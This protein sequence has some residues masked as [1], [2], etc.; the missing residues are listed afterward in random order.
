MKKVTDLN[1]ALDVTCGTHLQG[2]LYDMTYSELV[3]IF[4]E[5]TFDEP[6]GDHKIQREWVIEH[7]GFYFTIYDWKTYDL[8]Y[9][10]TQLS[11]FNV[12]GKISAYN[13]IEAVEK[14]KASL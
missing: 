13:F 5:P 14:A 12:G 2:Y 7:D 4:G 9:T 3:Q 8:D 11:Q 6:S 1:L 10:M